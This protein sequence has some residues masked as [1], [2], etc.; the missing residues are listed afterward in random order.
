MNRKLVSTGCSVFCS[1]R[2]TVIDSRRLNYLMTSVIRLCTHIH[3]LLVARNN[4]NRADVWRLDILQTLY[5]WRMPE[6]VPKRTPV[7]L[8]FYYNNFGKCIRTNFNHVSSIIYST[9][10]LVFDLLTPESD[11]LITVP[12]F[13]ITVRLMKSC[14]TLFKISC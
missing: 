14:L 3:V 11:T 6:G 1:S 7:F 2:S 13:I 8:Y 9:M 4:S 12:K 10:I 5:M